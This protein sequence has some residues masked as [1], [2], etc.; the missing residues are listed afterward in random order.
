MFDSTVSGAPFKF[1]LGK[2]E[3]ISGWD[4]GVAGMKVG[5]KRRLTIPANM[6]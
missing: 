1:T 4:V 6:A 2:K 3:V 5:G